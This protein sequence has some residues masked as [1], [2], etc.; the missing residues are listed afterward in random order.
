M[1]GV[2]M[3]RHILCLPAQVLPLSSLSANAP[4]VSTRYPLNPT[5]CSEFPSLCLKSLE[6]AMG[7]GGGLLLALMPAPCVAP[8]SVREDL[9]AWYEE[10]K[11]V[12]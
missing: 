6:L 12:E 11:D 5:E 1:L 9:P 3:A 7:A 2:P 10:S 4:L 8:V